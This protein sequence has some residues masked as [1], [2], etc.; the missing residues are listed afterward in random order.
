[1]AVRRRR[2]L[3][4]PPH[5]RRNRYSPVWDGGEGELPAGVNAVKCVLS[6]ERIGQFLRL[7]V[8]LA[9]GI[10]RDLSHDLI[11]LRLVGHHVPGLVDD[12][13]HHI[14]AVHHAAEGG[15][16]PIQMGRVLVHDEELYSFSFVNMVLIE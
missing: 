4:Q 5:P 8:R 7:R 2:P 10:H 14:H 11:L 16:L 15:V 3:I 12:A 1:M 13:I 9:V 6:P